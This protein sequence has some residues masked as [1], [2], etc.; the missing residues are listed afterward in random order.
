MTPPDGTFSPAVPGK[1][2]TAGSVGPSS[3]TG[4]KSGG[5]LIDFFTV[6][7]SARVLEE[8][9][10]T[11]ADHILGTVF[12]IRDEIVAGPIHERSWNFY[13]L[14]C[15]LVDRAG[16]VVGR[17]GFDG[18]GETVCVSLSGAGTRWVRDWSHRVYLQLT[19]LQGRITRC[20]VAHDDIDGERINVRAMRALAKLGS[21]AEGGRPPKHRFI[22]DDGHDTGC[23]LYVGQKGHK[24]LCIY[25][26]GKQLGLPESRWTRVEARFY[27]KH[28]EGRAVSLDVLR[29]PVA[30]LRGA[31]S[32]LAS[33]IAGA[34]ERMR[35]EKAKAEASAVAMKRWMRTQCGKAIGMVFRAFGGDVLAAAEAM[36]T[37]TRDGLPG[38]FKG[39]LTADL[40][41]QELRQ[42]L[43]SS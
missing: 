33:F 1:T 40:A 16:E 21:F 36:L 30:F 4:Q 15:V 22:D 24:E 32:V 42:C 8:N 17:M 20:D 14:S 19:R 43:V 29:D 6:V 5:A 26:K 18:N 31:Y 34:C 38:R 13:R 27:S 35:T 39:V 9:R 37:L 28:L 12:G 3:N 23:T 7:F 2:V 41:H 25:E 10:L 11:R